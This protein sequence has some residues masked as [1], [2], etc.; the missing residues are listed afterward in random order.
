SVET[1]NAAATAIISAESRVQPSAAQ[2]R[3]YGNCWS[4]YWCFGWNKPRKRI[5]HSVLVSSSE[6]VTGF[7]ASIVDSHNTSILLP[8]IA[9]PSSPT[10]F[11]PSHD[12]SSSPLKPLPS[13]DRTTLFTLGPYAHET[14]LVSPPVFSAFTT[15][16][17]TASFTPPPETTTPPSPEVPFA[18]LLSSSL[19][20]RPY[21]RYP[22][23]PMN[24]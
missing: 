16:P 1:V 15:E 12:P 18:E 20:F 13:V 17:S 3:S 24:N 22:G 4:I 2:R 11:L 5:S 8:S 6:P 23:S 21:Y 9:P 10:S 7:V 14:Q 19:E